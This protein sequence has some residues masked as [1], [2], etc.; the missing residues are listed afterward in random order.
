MTAVMDRVAPSIKKRTQGPRVVR[1][2]ETHCV[3]PDGELIGQPLILHSFWK[4]R[5]YELFELE[6]RTCPV[7]GEVAEFQARGSE[8][9]PDG[10]LCSV[11][12]SVLEALPPDIRRY[13]EALIGIPKKNAKTTI[14]AALGL[15]FLLAD[16]DPSAL[17]IS[18]A[19]SEQQ[20]ANLLYGSAKTMCKLSPTLKDLTRPFDKE[21]LVPSLPRAR[22]KNVASKSGTQDGANAKALLGDELHEW[23]GDRGRNLWTVL[24]GA[25]GAR[26]NP[27][28]LAITT[29]GYDQE[30]LCYE[31]YVYGQKVQR[32]EV[33]D[34]TFY[35]HWKAWPEG[36]DHR[37]PKV[38]AIANPLLG[39]SVKESYLADRVKRQP[40]SV[41]RR[42]HGNEWTTSEAIWVPFGVWDACKSDLALDSA[43]STYVAID[44][45]KWID[46]SALD[47][48]QRVDM[49]PLACPTCEEVGVTF[50]QTNDGRLPVCSACG[51]TIAHPPPSTRYPLRATI[52]ENPYP[53]HHELHGSWR[54]NNNLVMELCRDLFRRFP[55]PSCEIDGVT[56]PGPMFAYDPW[57]FRSEAETLSGEGLAMV[58]FPQ[59]DARMTE[60]SQN[61]F[62]AIMKGE[63][64]QDGDPAL[65]RHIHNVTAE[66]KER[67][68][69][70]SK[71]KGSKRKI[72]AA[73]AGGIAVHCAKVTPMPVGTGRSFY[74]THDLV[75]VR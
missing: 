70:M 43:R 1:F 63:V 12:A 75:V 38:W 56:M 41:V 13:T 7:C 52:W 8:D 17:V 68:W 23:D 54:M 45:A 59:T 73:I 30:S 24:S 11:C 49:S 74:E 61:F 26:N 48:A 60:A 10:Y 51:E 19:A 64:A 44:I 2:I 33:E 28:A 5:I 18:A 6:P 67:G 47:I 58:E 14:S 42:Y 22:M 3:H 9:A 53:E 66:Q 21:I 20:G 72:D 55:V 31:K 37:D 25:L 32:G 27:M 62:E 15:Y 35:F 71:P 29:A 36:S 34:R 57:R 69:R 50:D 40:E 46:S 16:G 65:K 39:V 4:Q